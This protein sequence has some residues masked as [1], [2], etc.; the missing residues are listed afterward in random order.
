MVILLQVKKLP[1]IEYDL[2]V[3]N[4]PLNWANATGQLPGFLVLT[5]TDKA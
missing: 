5:E 2:I 4:V 3:N 1:K